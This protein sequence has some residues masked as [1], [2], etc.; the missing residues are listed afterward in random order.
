MFKIPVINR[1][2]LWYLLVVLTTVSFTWHERVSSI[3]VTLLVAHWLFDKN[4][5]AKFY[6]AS[7]MSATQRL[8]TVLI[9]SFFFFHILGLLWSHHPAAGWHSIEVK[10]TF[11]LLPFLFSTENYLDDVKT[12]LLFLIFSFSCCL[13]FVYAFY[14]SFWHHHQEGWGEIISRMNISEGI[15]HPGYYS[16][17]FAYAFVWCVLEI[18][19]GKSR[20]KKMN[21]LLLL[22][23][24]FLLTALLLLASKTAILYVACFA[25]Y[26]IWMATNSV[27]PRLLRYTVFMAGIGLMILGSMQIPSIS[28]RI[29]E[30]FQDSDQLD[31][32]VPLSNSTG[33]RMAAW[34][35]EWS[36]IKENWLTGYGT[37]KQMQC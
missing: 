14:Y 8:I 33:S 20:N 13:S 3:G 30:T 26:L 7:Q 25:F 36:L 28:Y 11:L 1:A 9:W 15:M 19:S 29:K 31:K 23:I 22:L 10:L 21:I 6:K 5:P 18:I 16:N 32:N 12:T 4:L 35:S 34:T 2:S 24:S 27:R 37:G 17:Y